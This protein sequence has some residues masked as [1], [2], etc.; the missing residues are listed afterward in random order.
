MHY[1]GIDYGTKRIGLALATDETQPVPFRTLGIRNYEL[2]I[3]EV[4]DV[5]RD[6]HIDVIVVGRP[7]HLSADGELSEMERAIDQFIAH[8]A[9]CISLPIIVEDERL[10]SKAADQLMREYQT[11]GDRDSLAAMLILESYL[12]RKS[13]L[14]I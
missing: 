3:K 9:S 13:K 8:L 5:I 7:K 4:I 12:S 2:G 10:T 6:E 14:S 1:L 11:S